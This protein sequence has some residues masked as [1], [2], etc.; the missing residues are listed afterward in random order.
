MGQQGQQ[1][2]QS[3]QGQ[4][5][6]RDND[7]EAASEIQQLRNK[8]TR[9]EKEMGVLQERAQ[10]LNKKLVALCNREVWSLFQEYFDLII[11]LIIVFFF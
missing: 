10:M 2:Q 5:R 9:L 11:I 1:G 3:Q 8:N 6:K 4:K 7:D